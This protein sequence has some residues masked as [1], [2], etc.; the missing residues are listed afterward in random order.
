MGHFFALDYLQENFWDSFDTLC[1]I[2]LDSYWLVL[3]QVEI[4]EKLRDSPYI[5]WEFLWDTS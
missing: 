5:S 3:A 2:F 4:D 1:K